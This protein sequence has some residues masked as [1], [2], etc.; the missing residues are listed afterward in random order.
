MF[1]SNPQHDKVYEMILSHVGNPMLMKSRNHDQFSLF[2]VEIS[3][4]LLNEKRYL[5][6]MVLNDN[7]PIG[8]TDYLSNLKWK[9]FQC[10]SMEPERI[11]LQPH[12]YI[13]QR[14]L[15]SNVLLECLSRTNK[16]SVYKCKDYP[17][18]VSLLHT[19][20]LE[21]EYPND[22]SLASAIETYQTIIRFTD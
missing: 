19:R 21:Y 10:R 12:N 5:I 2:M 13:V 20:D 9:I 11:N 18:E 4:M 7:R 17:I 3:S 8:T 14:G 16:V 15:S 1:F 22:G 6:A